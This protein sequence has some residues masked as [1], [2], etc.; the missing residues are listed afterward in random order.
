MKV[1][2]VDDEA[3]VRHGIRHSID[4]TKLGACVEEAGNGREVLDRWEEWD[5]DLLITDIRMPLVDGIELIREAR[6]RKPACRCIVLSCADEFDYVREAL[7]LGASDYLLKMTVKPDEL[8]A[9]VYR[10]MGAAAAPD[11]GGDRRDGE[12]RARGRLDG[13]FR[14][15]LAYKYTDDGQIREIA[16]ILRLRAKL[17]RF[18][19]AVLEADLP[20][21]CGGGLA[22][23]RLGA[24]G[25]LADALAESASGETGFD[26]FRLEDDRYA[27]LFEAAPGEDEAAF[28][29][30]LGERLEALAG[31]L[32]AR[33]GVEVRVGISGTAVRPG[34]L[35]AAYR[36]AAK[37][38]ERHLFRSGPRVL[39]PGGEVSGRPED[40][41][42]SARFEALLRQ[43]LAPALALG[44]AEQAAEAVD[45]AFALLR[46]D[47]CTAQAAHDCLEKAA[48]TLRVAAMDFNR[49]AGEGGG[50]GYASLETFDGRPFSLHWSIPQAAE[51]LKDYVR[52]LASRLNRQRDRGAR[53]LIRDI[54]CYLAAHYHEQ[55]T[56][57]ETARRFHLNKNYLSQLF[58][59]ETGVTFTVY[60]NTLRIE[61]A[62]ERMMQTGETV[63][64]ISAKTGFNDFRYFSRVFRRMTGCTPT[65][66]KAGRTASP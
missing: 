23:G 45:A 60:L 1:L 53:K 61:K 32:A 12:D 49:H 2:I 28:A 34:R 30:R 10:V 26:V 36:E 48:A 35:A 4:W 42:V 16:R 43:R 13:F 17:E 51:R 56:L 55:I 41:A 5:P 25:A 22:D 66:Y 6:R 24:A 44:H 14:D 19:A 54:Q 47:R 21:S 20:A 33:A 29:R 52:Y 37:A 15:V 64:E 31:E 18:A 58:K 65:E 40:A 57:A 27:L 11:A 8:M 46:E 50:E 7:L 3:I 38:A 63:T 9:C 59:H 62:K 39:F